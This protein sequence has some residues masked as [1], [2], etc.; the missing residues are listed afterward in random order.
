[1]KVYVVYLIYQYDGFDKM[2][3][4]ASR[5]AAAIVA[6][7]ELE[8]FR[9]Q[10]YKAADGYPER[11]HFGD[12]ERPPFPESMSYRLANKDGEVE[13]N[14]EEQEVIGDRYRTRQEEIVYFK[15]LSYE[16]ERDGHRK[17]NDP[18][19]MAKA[20]AY[21]SA[22]FDLEHNTKEGWDK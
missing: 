22:A 17:G 7:K 14:I 10:G 12:Y 3:V 11:Y 2:M 6:S 8:S 1:M 21:R 20:E 13:I 4:C 5:E 18:V 16:F 9:N 19:L 15:Q